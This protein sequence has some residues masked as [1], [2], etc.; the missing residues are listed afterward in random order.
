MAVGLDIG[1]PTLRDILTEL[2]KPGRDPREELPSP[3]FR[4]D[5]LEI[6]DLKSGMI[7]M[8]LFAISRFWSICGYWCSPRWSCTYIPVIP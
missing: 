5:V 8:G 1:I 3:I 7:L 4:T 6:T 2:K